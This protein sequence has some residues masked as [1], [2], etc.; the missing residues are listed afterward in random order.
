MAFPTPSALTVLTVPC[1]C[2]QVDGGAGVTRKSIQ[3]FKIEFAGLGSTGSARGRVALF[4][5]LAGTEF[6]IA[7]VAD[8]LTGYEQAELAT[9]NT[10]R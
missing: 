5:G 1:L 7:G 2:V 3:N 8:G 4:P 9:G 6:E 10:S